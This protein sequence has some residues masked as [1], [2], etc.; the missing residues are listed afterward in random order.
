MINLTSSDSDD[1]SVE[2]KIRK[3]DAQ[4]P[5]IE[6]NT[7]KPIELSKVQSPRSDDSSWTTSPIPFNEQLPPKGVQNLVQKVKSDDSTWDDDSR[8][9]STD[10]SKRQTTGVDNLTKIMDTIMQ[11]TKKQASPKV[12]GKLVVSSMGGDQTDSVFSEIDKKEWSVTSTHTNEL[13]TIQQLPYSSF[14]LHDTGSKRSSSSSF[15]DVSTS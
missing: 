12:I 10:V 1:N 3:V 4:K 5:S 13:K 14:R 11:S 2:T 9:L 7:N 8:P 15:H 6:T